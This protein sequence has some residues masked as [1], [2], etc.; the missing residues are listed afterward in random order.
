TAA[1]LAAGGF[2]ALSLAGQAATRDIPDAP[3]VESLTS[4]LLDFKDAGDPAELNAIFEEFRSGQGKVTGL[5]SAAD[6]LVNP[7][8]KD[9]IQ[10]LGDSIFGLEQEAAKS[11]ATF[12]Q[13][14]AALASMV[15]GGDLEGAA[16]AFEMLYG[17][18]DQTRISEEQ[19]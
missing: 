14:G 19:F 4:A 13:L 6:L 8:W 18:V 5:A 15:S 11:E 17:M 12:E 2:I 7:D 10:G 16:L 1:G 3:G 9:N